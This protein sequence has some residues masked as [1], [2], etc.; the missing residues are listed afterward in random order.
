MPTTVIAGLTTFAAFVAIDLVW[1]TLM[2]P[3]LYRPQLGD[4]A[5]SNPR[6]APAIIFYLIYTVALTILV[7]LPAIRTNS[8]MQALINGAVFGLAAYATYNLTNLSTLARWPLA[9][10]VVDM[11]WGTVLTATAAFAVASVVPLISGRS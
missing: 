1:L 5:A 10:T 6:L 9:L 3:R 4:L 11:T 7:V 2:A 8:P